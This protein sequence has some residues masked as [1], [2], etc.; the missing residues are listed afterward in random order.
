MKD[1]T[2]LYSGLVWIFAA[3]GLTAYGLLGLSGSAVPGIEQI[4]DFIN[5]IDTRYIYFAAFLAMFIEGLYFIGSFFPG[6]GLIIV[7]AVLSQTKSWLTFA[8]TILSI[9]LGWCAAGI[10]NIMLAKKFTTY[11]HSEPVE[12]KDRPWVTWF[13][14]F[15]ANYEVSQIVAGA[16]VQKVFWSGVRVRIWGSIVATVH[17]ATL[18]LFIDVTEMQNEEGYISVLVVTAIMFIV[19]GWQICAY[20]KNTRSTQNPAP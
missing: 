4:V 7:I 14:A 19:G 10:I 16:D 15:R 2:Q 5:S 1:Q 9:F 12:V 6:S 13:P 17:V 18:P 20:K 3:I 11:T 8:F